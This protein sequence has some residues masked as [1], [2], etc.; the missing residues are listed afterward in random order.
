MVN[1]E[2]YTIAANSTKLKIKYVTIK[3]VILSE[4]MNLSVLSDCR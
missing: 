1:T 3:Y 2:K 4:A